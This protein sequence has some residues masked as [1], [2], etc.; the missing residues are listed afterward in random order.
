MPID[1]LR[2]LQVIVYPLVHPVRINARNATTQPRALV[3]LDYMQHPVPSLR[4]LRSRA[5]AATGLRRRDWHAPATAPSARHAL[6]GTTSIIRLAENRRARAPTGLRR[7]DQHARATVPS[8]R[9]ATLGTTKVET[10]AQ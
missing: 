10:L 3:N 8:V 4:R 6:R 7:R 5:R 1:V 2:V 9:R